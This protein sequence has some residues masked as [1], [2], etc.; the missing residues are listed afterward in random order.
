MLLDL[1]VG[2]CVKVYDLIGRQVRST[3]DRQ[4]NGLPS[5]TYLLRSTHGRTGQATVTR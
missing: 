4:I 3:C 1:A 5:G 2:E